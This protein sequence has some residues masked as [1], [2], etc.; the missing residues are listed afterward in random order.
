MKTEKVLKVDE[1]IN[2]LKKSMNDISIDFCEENS[3]RYPNY[4]SDAIAEYAD[5]EVS[6]YTY[7]Q[8]SFY[9]NNRDI[10]DEAAQDLCLLES[11]DARKDSIGDLISRA[12]VMGWYSNNI[13]QL[14]EDIDKI[15]EMFAIQRLKELNI[16]EISPNGW[17]LI[18]KYAFSD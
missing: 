13:N 15:R 2:E 16:S 12:G 17:D 10:C 9:L 18:K 4:L 3:F 14:N 7:E 8:E 6:V 11:F 1:L 5:E